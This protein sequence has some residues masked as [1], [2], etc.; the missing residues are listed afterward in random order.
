[1][2]LE[3]FRYLAAVVA[4]HPE[5]RIVGR[6]RLQKT[7]K[8]LQRLGLPTDYDYMTYFYGPYSSGVQSDIGLLE[9]LRAVSEEQ[10]TSQDGTPY[11]VVTAKPQ[12]LSHV[13]RHVAQRPVIIGRWCRR[14]PRI[15]PSPAPMRKRLIEVALPLAKINEAAAREK[16]VRHGHPSTLHLWWARR[17]LA[18]CRA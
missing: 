18:V 9:R 14:Q 4:A 11:Y 16:S 13:L 10:Q 7:V 5:R 15:Q 8:L 3:K 12:W 1:M 2:K 6:T 17:P